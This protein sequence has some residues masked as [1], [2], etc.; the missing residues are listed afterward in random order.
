VLDFVDAKKKELVWRGT[1]SGVI[2]PGKTAEQI[3]E[4]ITKMLENFPPP[5]R[6]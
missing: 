5:K 4:V 6:Q 2:D 3:N 1:A